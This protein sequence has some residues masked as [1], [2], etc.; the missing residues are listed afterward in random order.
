[1]LSVSE[2][3]VLVNLMTPIVVSKGWPAVI[4]IAREVQERMMKVAF[5]SF[6]SI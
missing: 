5:V 6:I 1:M 4:G 3:F 2:L